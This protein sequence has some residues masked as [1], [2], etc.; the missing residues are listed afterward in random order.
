MS[1]FMFLNSKITDG[2]K[3]NKLKTFINLKLTSDYQATQRLK[4][5]KKINYLYLAFI[6]N[7]TSSFLSFSYC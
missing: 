6:A 3:E 1:V 2:P 7:H 4:V 5:E